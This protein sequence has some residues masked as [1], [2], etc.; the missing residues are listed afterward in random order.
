MDTINKRI[1]KIIEKERMNYSTFSEVIGVSSQSIKNICIGK[2]NPSYEVIKAVIEKFP[3]YDPLWFTIGIGEMNREDSGKEKELVQ[4]LKRE[5]DILLKNNESLL[6]N[7]ERLWD[8]VDTLGKKAEANKWTRVV[9]LD[10]LPV[11]QIA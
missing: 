4:I 7:N 11:K 9:K 3:H 6:K 1:I 5:N 2:N 8:M 10:F